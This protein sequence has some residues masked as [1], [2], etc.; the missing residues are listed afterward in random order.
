M[1]GQIQPCCGH[2]AL[3]GAP[4]L[5]PASVGSDVP[6]GSS[7]VPL[8]PSAVRLRITWPPCPQ[9][10]VKG[11][12]LVPSVSPAPGPA[13]RCLVALLLVPQS[14]PHPPVL[15]CPPLTTSPFGTQPRSHAPRQ[16]LGSREHPVFNRCSW[17]TV[18]SPAF[19]DTPQPRPARKS[20]KTLTL[21]P[22]ERTNMHQLPEESCLQG[23]GA[24]R[25]PPHNFTHTDT[26]MQGMCVLSL[27]RKLHIHPRPAPAPH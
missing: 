9:G 18:Q 11:P 14:S 16:A 15:P 8:S 21:S 3:P 4:F 6:W 1:R 20:P 17:G 26:R 7:K 19:P 13:P 24:V 25:T 2:A 12:R 10:S 5:A 23:V 22:C 27:Q